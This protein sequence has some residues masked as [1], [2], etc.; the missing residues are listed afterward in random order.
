MNEEL[1]KA[2]EADKERKQTR[3]DELQAA[4]DY[5]GVLLGEA[6]DKNA[7]LEDKRQEAD[8]LLERLKKKENEIDD[9]I[10]VAESEKK[11]NKLATFWMCFALAE[12][13]MIVVVAMLLIIHSGSL[14]GRTGLPESE[15]NDAPVSNEAVVSTVPTPEP[16]VKY[17][18]DLTE[19]ISSLDKEAIA[20]FTADIKKIDGLEYLVFTADK[21]SVAYKNEYLQDEMGYRKAVLIDNGTERYTLAQGYDLTG[22]LK[23][24]VPK[25][26]AIDGENMVVFTEYNSR[27]AENI[28]SFIRLVGCRDFRSYATNDLA[29]LIKSGTVVSE[30]E[31]LSVFEDAPIVYTLSTEK[32]VYKFAI[33][34]GYYNDIAY[35]EHV[36]PEIDRDFVLTIDGEGISWKT[37]VRLG[38]DLYLGGLS[39]RLKIE[40][41]ALAVADP[42]FGAIVPPNQEDPELAGY[43][44]PASEFPERYITTFGN[45]GERFFVALDPDIPECTY[46]WNR[47]NTEDA[48]N[49]YYSDADGIKTSIRGIDVSKYQGNINWKKVA[50]AGVEFAIVRMGFRGMNEGTLETDPYFNANM[51]GATDNGIKVGVYFFSQAVNEKEAADE[52]A[53][54]L[55]SISGYNVEYPVIF[56]TERVTTYDARANSLNMETRTA[57][58]RTFCERITEA[59]YKP[60]IYANTKYMV[61]GIDLTKLKDID[62][63][64]AV[65]NPTITF[66]YDFQMLQY[67]EKGSI[68]GI[69]GNVDLNIS[70]VDYSK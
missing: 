9:L 7:L 39:G 19:K 43:I 27:I 25:L 36:I 67:S 21:V 35:N 6:E 11:K 64:Y 1:E 17:A 32:D 47:L 54:V 28:P 57:V 62:K 65:Y 66:P 48:N 4:R 29:G 31:E 20:P 60:M 46:D 22:D 69:S 52:A 53:F 33:S 10:R 68:P 40:N 14:T 56:D 5:V 50:E 51:K 41:G 37:K 70:F 63:W 44:R 38:E 2:Y 23:A 30:S 26:T 55:R 34:E 58:A 24:L 49:W 61:M 45:A 18:E 42:K 15:D 13:L 3:T 12:L 59:G 8:E 16:T